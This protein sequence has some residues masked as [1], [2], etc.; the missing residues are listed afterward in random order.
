MKHRLFTPGPTPIPDRVL[1]AMHAQPLYHRAEEFRALVGRIREGLQYLLQTSGPVLTLSCSGT[2]G[3]ESTFVSLFSPGDSVIAVNG[4]KFG[5]RWVRMPRALGLEAIEVRTPWG[6]AVTAKEVLQALRGHPQARAVYLTYSETSTG[7]AIDLQS[8]ARVIREHSDALV[9]VDAITAA[10]ALELRCDEWGIDVC[11][12]GSQK[13]LMIPPG[14][15]V[16]ALSERATEAMAEARLPRFY[17][18]LRQALEADRH[19]LTP[20]TPAISLY[21][22]LAESLS[23]IREE[24]LE[25]IWRRHARIAAGLRSGVSALGLRLFS[26]SPSNAVTAVWLPE[27]VS[28]EGFRQALDVHA[29]VT[30]AGGQGE[31]AGKIFRIGHLGYV[32]DLDILAVVGAMELALARLGVPVRSRRGYLGCPEERWLSRTATGPRAL[33]SDTQHGTPKMNVLISDALDPRCVGILE[34]EGH[35]VKNAPG[36]SAEE[37][38]RIIP[39]F[40]VLLVRSATKVTEQVIAAGHKASHHRAGRHG[41]G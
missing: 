40:E 18:D 16:V 5:E 19:G 23:M 10:G 25:A 24:G 39:E 12:T 22:G 28:W 20:W 29:G 38:L 14:L 4:G 15:A 7:T 35:T 9:C 36:L 13:G 3:M 2:G 34:Q 1:Q 6:E 30:L 17:L 11:V 41:S 27:G 26:R 8:I 32:D 21:V 31:Y 33:Q 37:L